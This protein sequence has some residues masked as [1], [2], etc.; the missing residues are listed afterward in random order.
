MLKQG[1]MGLQW[2][3]IASQG[4]FDLIVQDWLNELLAAVT[5]TGTCG[6]IDDATCSVQHLYWHKML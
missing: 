6:V 2:F 4:G 5:S 3:S 1:R